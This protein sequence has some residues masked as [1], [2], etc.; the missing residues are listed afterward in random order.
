MRCGKCG[1]IIIFKKQDVAMTAI[2]RYP[3]RFLSVLIFLSASALYGQTQD[4]ACTMCHSNSSLSMTRQGRSISLFVDGAKIKSSAHGAFSCSS[5]H[6]NFNAMAVPH[7]NPVQQVNCESCHK[8]DGFAESV[9]AKSGVMTCKNCHGTHDVQPV[10]NPASGLARTAV[11]DACGKCHAAESTAYKAS[12]H[13][14]LLDQMPQSPTC[15]NCHGAH[16]VLT[17]K[18]VESPLHRNNEPEFC[19]SCHLKDSAVREKVR[20]SEHFMSGYKDSVHG[21]KRAAGNDNAAICGD[22]HGVHDVANAQKTTSGISRWNLADTCGK[23]HAE[24]SAAFKD[25]IHG[26]SV[27]QGSAESPTCTTCHG[28]HHIYSAQ[29]PRSAVSRANIAEQACANCHNSVTITQKYGI[30]SD[31]F[32]SFSDSFHGL[33]SKGGSLEVANC[34]SCHGSHNIKPS[35]D[36]ASTVNIAHLTTTCAQCHPGAK[37]NFA[38][39]KVHVEISEASDGAIY[40]IRKIYIILIIATIGLMFIHNLLD[41]IKRTRRRFEVRWGRRPLSTHSPKQ[42][43]RMTLLDRVQ[44]AGLLV[45]FL[46]L[47]VTGFMLR[48]PDAWWVNAI[49]SY[50]T[51]FFEM[52]GIVHRGAAVVI[53]SFSL[54]HLFVLIFTRHGR[55]LLAD[56][57]PKLSD[58]RDVLINARHLLGLSPD[59]PRFDRFGYAEKAEYWALVWGMVIMFATGI[60]L[61]FFNFFMGHFGKIGWDIARTIHYYEALLATLAI[62]VWHFY[63]V[64]FNPSIYPMNTTW[65][66]GKISE[67]EMAE[68]HPLELERIRRQEQEAQA[69]ETQT[70][71]PSHDAS[72][73]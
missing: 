28:D 8:I 47:A 64:M 24:I 4:A 22:C 37:D 43:V 34:A 26:Q 40:W 62:I 61:W 19:L 59:H 29:D 51:R 18:S 3:I 27:A 21:Q 10:K 15:V 54:F 55:K 52:R 63:F 6:T 30:P 11:A 9:H 25:S 36:P 14:I 45:S 67:K 50:W 33:A 1:K 16:G 69:R 32:A 44:H 60:F 5:C 20:F 68:E 35:S 58:A 66:T 12:E 23:C 31:R 2:K 17:V 71:K 56:I 46:T 72:E 42:Y 7:A 57:F 48:F 38:R 73:K 70:Q 65:F 13:G 49:R 39:G 41:F 53:I